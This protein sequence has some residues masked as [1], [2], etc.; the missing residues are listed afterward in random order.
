MSSQLHTTTIHCKATGR[1]SWHLPLLFSSHI[2][3][4]C[5]IARCVACLFVGLF[6]NTRAL[7]L[8]P[9]IL[10]YPGVF[11]ISA[12]LLSVREL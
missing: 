1:D 11:E 7:S 4:P 12:A 3:L 10:P 8:Q 9:P 6:T 2:N 5:Y